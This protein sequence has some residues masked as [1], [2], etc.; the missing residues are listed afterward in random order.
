[1]TTVKRRL[2]EPQGESLKKMETAR[3]VRSR[4]KAL[5]VES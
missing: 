5:A 3:R 4:G 2:A 1:M